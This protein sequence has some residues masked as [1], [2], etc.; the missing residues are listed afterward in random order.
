MGVDAGIG[1]DVWEPQK[2]EHEFISSDINKGRK[3]TYGEYFEV[4]KQQKDNRI[5]GADMRNL[6]TSESKLPNQSLGKIWKLSDINKIG[7]LD[8]EEYLLCLHLM[9]VKLGKHELP[10]TLPD[11]LLP[12]STKVNQKNSQHAMYRNYDNNCVTAAQ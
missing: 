12:P 3:M 10:K 11:H 9:Q 1:A 6:L 5:S 4:K 2:R 8:L 7:S